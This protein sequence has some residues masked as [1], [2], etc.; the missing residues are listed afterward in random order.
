MLGNLTSES[1]Q[2]IEDGRS[3]FQLVLFAE[4]S[5][6]LVEI[7]HLLAMQAIIDNDLKVTEE[8]FEDELIQG[9]DTRVI[10][11]G[12]NFL[13]IK[14]G[15]TVQLIHQTVRDFLLSRN[16]EAQS[17]TN[18]RAMFML[19]GE[20]RVHAAIASACI[21]YLQL[22]AS[23]ESSSPVESWT[24]ETFDRYVE[25]LNHWILLHY[26][27]SFLPH[28]ISRSSGS[29]HVRGLL[30]R[31]VPALH[32]KPI[33]YLLGTWLRDEWQQQVPAV[34]KPT[35][36][37]QFEGYILQAA[38]KCSMVEALDF[39]LLGG[40]YLDE[41]LL[42]I[43]YVHASENMVLFL[44]NRK[45]DTRV[46]GNGL[47]T[48]LHYASLRGHFEVVKVLAERNG[49]NSGDSQGLTPLHLATQ[50]A[51]VDM[52][53]LLEEKGAIPTLTDQIENW[54]PLHW[55]SY[56]GHLRAVQYFMDPDRFTP[57]LGP[58]LLM[59]LKDR[60]GK[61]ALYIAAANDKPEIVQLLLERGA[62]PSAKDKDSLTP[63][64]KSAALGHERVVRC[65][66]RWRREL[67][68]EKDNSGRT[69]L[70]HAAIH[71]Q[72]AILRVLAE[73][74]GDMNL[75]TKDGHTTLHLATAADQVEAI[76]LLISLGANVNALD[77]FD[78]TAL[79]IAAYYGF[80]NSLNALTECGADISALDAERRD[81]LYL[82][83]GRGR[84]EVV[85]SLL[86]HTKANVNAKD[87]RGWTPLF[88]A[89]GNRHDEVVSLLVESGAGVNVSD[90]NGV[91]SLHW[92]AHKGQL[93]TVKLLLSL[94][95]NADALDKN[96]MSAG[97]WAFH[98]GWREISALFD[99]NMLDNIPSMLWKEYDR[100]MP[101]V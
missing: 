24:E 99:I 61:T 66:V 1:Q 73:V 91:T 83:A 12:A 79:H 94:G 62:D 30:E 53:R 51:N 47:R 56:H 89:A 34:S 20:A 85:V 42:L 35:A 97:D 29:A 19:D 10:H 77:S 60:K 13:E 2:D 100:F 65:F 28:H 71:G 80:L 50:C 38:V 37:T 11:C 23:C 86:R 9:M 76:R 45:V 5:L 96:E 68:L 90:G 67:C 98:S 64:M 3:M 75:S 22:A 14:G 36:S 49:V 78:T 44:I 57:S 74:Q 39:I 7:Q 16:I 95:A 31:V 87:W 17:E 93:S 41:S 15:K 58:V 40:T 43:A 18:A 46:E 48:G 27:R 101:G 59:D 4:R 32:D 82:A 25:H 84:T 26:I 21:H 63:L 33:S 72:L 92:A 69:A 6:T 52:M 88:W 81:A 54:T 8:S 70:S 55:A